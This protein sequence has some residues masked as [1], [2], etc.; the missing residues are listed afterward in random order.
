[1][2]FAASSTSKLESHDPVLN[3]PN[4]PEF[5]PSWLASQAFGMPDRTVQIVGMGERATMGNC[6]PVNVSCW[7]TPSVV[8]IRPARTLIEGMSCRPCRWSTT[9]ESD[10]LRSWSRFAL[11]WMWHGAN[12]ERRHR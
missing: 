8:G 3:F 6:G 5:Y 11:L 2:D 1:M 12:A 7:P 10:P 9:G 4:E